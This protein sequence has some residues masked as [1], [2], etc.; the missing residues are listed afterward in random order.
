[1][2]FINFLLYLLI[3][4]LLWLRYSVKK[5]NVKKIKKKG[6]KGILFLPTHP[7]L[8]DTVILMT[9][10][11]PRFTPKI[12]ADQ[13]SVAYPIIGKLAPRFGAITMPTVTKNGVSEWEKIDEVLTKCAEGL[14][15]GENWVLYPS[16]HILTSHYE[17]IGG[18]S[19]VK[20][21]LEKAPDARIVIVRTRGIWGSSLSVAF[22]GKYPNISKIA[23][24]CVVQIFSALVFFLPRRKVTMEFFEPSDF[25]RSADK[26]VINHY[27]EGYFNELPLPNNRYYSYSIFGSRK[28]EIRPEPVS[29]DRMPLDLSSVPDDIRDTV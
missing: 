1:M 26:M 17:S 14:K 12:I 20:R 19:A 18:N 29:F 13:N 21:I 24:R 8:I 25:P 4:F 3:T 2:K 11:Y 16:G 10:L 28:P 6:R 27:I 9:I 22:T 7:S 5:I 23:K 15:N